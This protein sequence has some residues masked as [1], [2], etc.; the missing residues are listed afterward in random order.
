MESLQIRP[1][2]PLVFLHIPKT[3]GTNVR[4]F[5]DGQ[6]SLASICRADSW[7]DVGDV[8]N[9]K[10]Y[11]LIRG[12]FSFSMVSVLPSTFRSFTVLRHPLDRMLSSLR[13]MQRD[14]GFHSLHQR[15]K[16]R[17][18][19][20]ILRDPVIMDQQR[21][22]QARTLCASVSPGAIA[23]YVK[24]RKGRNERIDLGALESTPVTLDLA[25]ERLEQIDFIGIFEDLDNSIRSL[26][27]A[28]KYHPPRAL[29][30]RNHAPDG[31]SEHT[32]MSTADIEILREYNKIDLQ[33]YNYARRL[34][35]ERDQSFL[36]FDQ[37][38]AMLIDSDA[39]TCPPGSFAVDL[40]Q[41]IPGSGWY[42]PEFHDGKAVRWT[43]PTPFA[44]LELPLNREREHLVEFRFIVTDPVLME[45]FSVSLDGDAIA[46]SN[47]TDRRTVALSLSIPRSSRAGRPY[48]EIILRFSRAIVPA[49]HGGADLRALGV[50]VTSIMFTVLPEASPAGLG[51]MALVSDSDEA[52]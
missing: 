32:T 23:Q 12:H 35:L 42:P 33:L 31:L 5:L 50:L 8:D 34:V 51:E 3:A 45:G 11:S 36:C 28:M 24:E 49:D 20:D 25:K 15:A 38:L 19:S 30:Y 4:D 9:L 40:A 10:D 39:Y 37:I 2:D 52:Q 46:F 6:Y 48:T 41:P 14:P 7:I 16:G 13:H 18:I 43:G 21:D 44:T 26:S 22:V 27:H 17:T 1:R 47:E 29:G